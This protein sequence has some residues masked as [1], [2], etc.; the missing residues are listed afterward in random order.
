MPST[1]AESSAS[2]RVD[3]RPVT[4][5]WH[6]ASAPEIADQL[7]TAPETADHHVQRRRCSSLTPDLRDGAIRDI[8]TANS[9]HSITAARH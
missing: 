7:M 2:H 1:A 3:R 8:A 5:T 4:P 6:P 9:E